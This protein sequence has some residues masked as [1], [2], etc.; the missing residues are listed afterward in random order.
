[1]QTLLSQKT[2]TNEKRFTCN[3]VLKA[4]RISLVT[5]MAYST[6]ATGAREYGVI[7]NSNSTCGGF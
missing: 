3:G 6:A 5:S 1:M 4:L 7:Q 2:R